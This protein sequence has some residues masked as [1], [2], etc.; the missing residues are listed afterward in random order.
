MKK[1]TGNTLYLLDEP[2]TGL[3]FVDI[4]KLLEVI[5][6]LI[7]LGNSVVVIE[8]NSDVVKSADH[9]I[10]LKPEGGEKG[11]MVVA[12]GTPEEVSMNP[13]SY[14]GMFLRSNHPQ[15]NPLPLEGEGRERGIRINALIKQER[16]KI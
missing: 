6:S 15:F 7:D 11:G 12:F 2:T 16:H 3:H 10:D 1:S 8:H 13:D 5:N 14:T 9:I 4:Q